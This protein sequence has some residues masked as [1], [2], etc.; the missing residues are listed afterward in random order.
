MKILI[1]NVNVLTPYSIIYGGSVAILGEKIIGVYRDSYLNGDVY[2]KVIDGNGEYLSAGFIDI[3]NHGN[4]GHDVMEGTTE[5]LD[6]MARFHIK[7]GVL[8]FLATTMTSSHEDTI[9]AIKNVAGYIKN[10][11]TA[12]TNNPKAHILG[13]Y[14]EGP[15]FSMKR[16]GAQPG[17]FIKNPCI[18]EIES[19]IHASENNVKIIVLAPELPGAKE[20]ITYIKSQGITVSAGHS[21]ATYDEA[22]L[23]IE[24]GVTEVTHIYNGMRE[25]SHRE[26][27]I[28]GAALTDERVVCEMICDGI[29]L[30]PAAMKIVVKMKDKDRIILISDA[31]MAAGLKD[32]VYTLGVQTVYVKDGVARLAEGNLAGSTLTLNRAVYNM[33]H[34]CGVKLE[35]AVRMATLNP[36]KAIG[37]DK[38]KGSIEIGKDADLIMF[39]RDIKVGLAMI[40]GK[41]MF[42]KIVKK[43][44]KK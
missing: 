40:G 3:H 42:N 5:A 34:F 4:F 41:I 20:A 15:Y 6:S 12:D 29:H 30:S 8:G 22:M 26:P 38:K 9:K 44:S 28:I 33:V 17:Q 14:L 16:K 35:D 13:L 37:L 24:N 19:F 27:G 39:N 2:D 32:G 1:K 7:N 23:G 11:N 18:E 25:F 10:H 31:M 21:D 43:C 36:A